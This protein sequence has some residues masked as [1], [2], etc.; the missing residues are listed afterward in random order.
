MSL[1]DVR[2]SGFKI[3]AG[4]QS[5]RVKYTA[6]AP[7]RPLCLEIVDVRLPHGSPPGVKQRDWIVRCIS[8]LSCSALAHIRGKKKSCY[9][10]RRIIRQRERGETNNNRSEDIHISTP[11]LCEPEYSSFLPLHLLASRSLQTGGW[12]SVCAS[13]KSDTWLQSAF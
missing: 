1:A 3:L 11:P 10:S 8:R 9:F 7:W 6:S 5:T 4:L 12:M 13:C 2:L